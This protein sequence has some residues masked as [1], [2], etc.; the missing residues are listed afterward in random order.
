MSDSLQLHG[1]YSPWNPPGQNT[2]VRSHSL[3]QGIFPTQGSNP[4]LPL[5]RWILYPLNHQGSQINLPVVI[6]VTKSCPTLCDPMDCSIPGFPVLH[7]LPEL[8]QIHVHWVLGYQMDFLCPPSPHPSLELL[9]YVNWNKIKDQCCYMYSQVSGCVDSH[10][11]FIF[12][13]ISLGL[14]GSKLVHKFLPFFNRKVYL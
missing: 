7:H 4:G 8:A 10:T 9:Y 11:C 12:C 5:C 1:L 2:R 6:V 14:L 3:L 13:A